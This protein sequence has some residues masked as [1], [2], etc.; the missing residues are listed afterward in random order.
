MP[1]MFN[2]VRMHPRCSEAQDGCQ[3]RP[4]VSYFS[5]KKLFFFPRHGQIEHAAL[6]GIKTHKRQIKVRRH[7]CGVNLQEDRNLGDST[8]TP[9]ICTDE[10]VMC[11][12]LFH[13]GLEE[14]D[15]KAC[16]YINGLKTCSASTAQMKVCAG[17]LLYFPFN[18]D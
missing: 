1:L 10:R 16:N 18:F 14:I 13:S 3:T 9:V 5:G 11:Q 12:E 8:R 7:I 6:A 17:R 15:V 2:T 4:A